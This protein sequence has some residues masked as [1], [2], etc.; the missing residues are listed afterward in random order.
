MLRFAV[1]RPGYPVASPRS[2]GVSRRDVPCRVHVGV[3]GEIAGHAGEESLALAALR[4]DV[5]ARRATLARERGI[6][7]LYP[8]GSLVFQPSYQSAPSL[9]HDLAVQPGLLA[10]VLARFFDSSACRTGHVLDAQVF[11]ADHVEPTREIGADFLAPV[12]TYA[13]SRALS[14]AMASFTCPRR[15]DPRF[16]RASLRW[17]WRSLRSRRGLSRGTH[18]I[19]PVDSA[20]LTLTPRSSPAT[21]PVP[22]P[23]TGSGM[24]AKAIC[25]RLA[26]SRVTR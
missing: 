8:A 4:C 17:R 22:G 24:A 11:D 1:R 26:R 6:D 18:S 19:S 20:A 12:L 23:G 3:A 13:A 16:A 2:H 5:P 25:Q 14:R 10:D 15:F 21:S 7:L 9:P